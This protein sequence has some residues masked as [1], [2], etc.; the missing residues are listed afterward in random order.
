SV[1]LD[2]VQNL[3][4]LNEKL[5][6]EL[7]QALEVLAAGHSNEKKT[8]SLGF[9][10]K[11]K[12]AVRV[13]YIQETPIWKTSYRLVIRE[14]EGPLLQGWAIVENTTEEDWNDVSLSLISGRPIAFRMDL[15]QPL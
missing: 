12:R 9:Q 11:G 6:G 2:Q 15:Y 8:V 13:G 5:A 10:G 3:K 14:E 4:I 7:K 1:E